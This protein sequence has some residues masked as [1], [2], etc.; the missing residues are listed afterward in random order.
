MNSISYLKNGWICDKEDLEDM[1]TLLED[2]L[3]KDD[4]Q[5]VSPTPLKCRA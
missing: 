4:P 1:E 5:D 3:V 2:R